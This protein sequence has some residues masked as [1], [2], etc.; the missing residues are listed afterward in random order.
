MAELL[1]DETVSMSI[2]ADDLKAVLPFKSTQ[3][4]RYYLNGVLVEKVETGGCIL[5]ATNGH[6]LVAMHSPGAF[7][8]QTRILTVSDGL[9]DAMRKVDDIQRTVEVAGAKG[10]VTLYARGQEVF[11]QPREPFI[12]GKFPDWRKVVPATENL[13][14]GLAAAIS[15][16]YLATL[17][18]AI[19]RSQQRNSLSFW[20]Q[21]TDPKNSAIVVRYEANHSLVAVVMPM[22][23]KHDWTWPSWMK[24]EPAQE[25]AA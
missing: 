16:E 18:R 5:V 4:I 12:D 2:P 22:Q 21:K 3:D 15:S 23:L 14:P 10:R 6:I 20:H 1:P 9:S 8:D 11:I 13:E 24:R 19:P 17:K 7:I 25:S